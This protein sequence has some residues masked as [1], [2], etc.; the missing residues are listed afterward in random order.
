MAMFSGWGFRP[1]N[2]PRVL[3]KMS[4]KQ[5]TKATTRNSSQ[6]LTRTV[7]RH[8]DMEGAAGDVLLSPLHGQNIIS[9]LLDDVCD[10]V[11]LVAHM[12]HGDLFAGRGGPVDPDQQHVGTW[13]A[14]EG[15]YSV[16]MNP[17]RQ[18]KRRGDGSQRMIP[19][20]AC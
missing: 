4:Y 7:L 13:E 15:G 17:R 16:R 9:L 20:T 5:A 8:R 2:R 10:V 11:L 6:D 1:T 3:Y 14:E 12:L 18:R 19:V